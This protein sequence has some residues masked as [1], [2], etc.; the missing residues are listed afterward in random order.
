MPYARIAPRHGRASSGG[1]TMEF[2]CSQGTVIVGARALVVLSP[3]EKER[4]VHVI[5]YRRLTT[6]HELSSRKSLGS[7]AGF[8]VGFS[9][10]PQSQFQRVDFATAEEQQRF[11]DALTEAVRAWAGS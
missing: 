9:H 5:P 4:A 7:P 10:I 6:I 11:M 2:A 1:G 8:A 3:G